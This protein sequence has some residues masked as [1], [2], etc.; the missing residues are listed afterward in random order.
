VG[1][2]AEESEVEQVIASH[3]ACRWRSR[4]NDSSDSGNRPCVAARALSAEYISEKS[5]RGRVAYVGERRVPV[6]GGWG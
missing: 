2:V 4:D 1:A 3:A 6:P 5:R